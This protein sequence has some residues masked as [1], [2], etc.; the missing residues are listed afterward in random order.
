[1]NHTKCVGLFAAFFLAIV[2]QACSNSVT[3][4]DG[5][6]ESLPPEGGACSVENLV[7]G[8]LDECGHGPQ[9]VCKG[10]S[11][12]I[13]YHDPGPTDCCG[14]SCPPACPDEQ[15]DDAAP[16]SSEGAQCSYTNSSCAE[17]GADAT[18]VSGVW[19][20]SQYG[21]AC[22]PFCPTTRPVEGTSC[23][24]CCLQ[25]HCNFLDE[26][27]CPAAFSCTNG[28][29]V[30]EP[31]SCAPTSD[32]FTKDMGACLGDPACRWLVYPGCPSGQPGFAQGCYP[33]ADCTSD[34]DCGGSACLTV[35]VDPCPGAD[36][37][38]CVAEAHICL[39]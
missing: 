4:A 31:S 14:V 35:E 13:D 10:G 18:C 29:W 2:A 7:C 5:C 20:V 1:M 27:G 17:A 24:G 28:V 9:A 36:C 19:H 6:P 22:Q 3:S 30:S 38:A 16:C 23:D 32:C 34:A 15:P 11:W 37:N 21:P 12:E 8:Q 26:S 25:D 33:A 39:L